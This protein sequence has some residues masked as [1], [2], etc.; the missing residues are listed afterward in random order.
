M[1]IRPTLVV[2]LMGTLF[3]GFSFAQTVTN[4]EALKKLSQEYQQ[5]WEQ[6]QL[7][8]QQYAALHQLP[9][10]EQMEDGTYRQMV[11][12]REGIPV[13]YVTHNYGAAITT[14][15]NTIWPGGSTGLDLTGDG[16]N[17]LGE[18]DAGAVRISH[19]E[20]T[21]QGS[22][23]VTKMDGAG[24]THY[25]ATHV[26]G[27]MVAAGVVNAAK[28]MVYGANLKA[29]E[30][31]NDNSEMAAAAANGLEI[32]NHSYGYGHGWQY[33]STAHTWS[34]YGN[35]S[36]SPTEDYK[37]GF[38]NN[39]SKSMDNIA[40]NA[41][42]YLIVKSA[43][44]DRGEGPGNAGQNGE[45]EVDGGLDGYDCIGAEEVAKNILT[46]GAVK[47][48]LDYTGPE[49]VVMSSFSCW[50]PADDGRIKPDIVGKGVSVYST[51]DGSNTDYS[52]LDGT[53]MSAP[54]VSGS[55][56]MLQYYYQSTHGGVPMRS[57]TLKALVLHTADEAGLYPGPDYIFGWGLMNAKRATTVI[58]EDEY[59]E[60]M[61]ELVLNQ[62][63]SYDRDVEIA[64]GT[65]FRVTI[66]WTD[67]AGQPLSPQL[68]P[69]NPMLV[70]DLDLRIVD[71]SNNTYYPYKLD[72]NDPSAAATTDSKNSVD[73]VEMV[74]IENAPAGTYTIEVDHDGSLSGNAQ[75][76]SIIISGIDEFT[77]TPACSHA[78]LTPA[79]GATDAFLDQWISWEPAQL[80]TSYDVFFGTDGG[81]VSTPVNILNGTNFTENGFTYFM[82]ENTTYY[83]EVHPRNSQGAATACND[84]WS[85]TTMPAI[86]V[87]P[88]VEGIENVSVPELPQYWQGKDNSPASWSST[89]L[90]KHNG[91]KG[92]ACYHPDGLV[93]T[94]FDNWLITPP[95]RVEDG[96]EYNISYYFRGFLPTNPETMSLYWG[97]TT[98]AT[99]MTNLLYEGVGFVYADWQLANARFMPQSDTVVF[100]G[101]HMSS[102]QGYGTFLDDVLIEDW[103]PV[104]VTTPDAAQEVKIYTRDNQIRVEAGSKWEGAQIQ[105]VNLV[106]QTVY[107]GMFKGSQSLSIPNRHKGIYLVSLKKDGNIKTKKIMV[108]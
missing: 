29:W 10:T 71:A 2:L 21:D 66:C 46:V 56:A 85:F 87:Y 7:R 28:G 33:N 101:W 30:W 15:I 57:A 38:Y 8:V 51:M 91:T 105:V 13:Y 53:S 73:N 100:F 24:A 41:P 32:S 6:S 43:G 72:R 5:E 9:I 3:M 76:F 14:R 47:E 88:Y 96:K 78:L 26:A 68:N 99:D 97:Y 16:Y 55:M 102:V 18:W 25:H 20:F 4:V 84:I 74:Y 82:Q 40:F 22:S 104:S 34:W 80:A 69:P 59:Q 98:A 106:G 35:P 37:F 54:N 75:A 58:A 79:E 44:N 103:G 50:G 49:S 62:G 67:P 11:D 61:E 1:K 42:N 36:V 77:V 95:F 27:T 81:G 45:P 89:D 19:Q 94:D 64:E 86:D 107:S 83:L 39:D 63:S 17:Q 70:N 93:L 108:N 12:V 65:N 52:S 23:R 90:I 48:V 31:S 60:V 92:L